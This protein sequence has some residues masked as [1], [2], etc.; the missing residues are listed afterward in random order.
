MDCIAQAL[1]RPRSFFF[2]DPE[3]R[4]KPIARHIG[5]VLQIFTAR[6]ADEATRILARPNLGPAAV[7]SF[8][9]VNPDDKSKEVDL[10]SGAVMR[11][12][13]D[14]AAK[15]PGSP[16]SGGF[17]LI[18]E[19]DEPQLI[20]GLMPRN[21]AEF[22]ITGD[23]IDDTDA[24]LAGRGGS[25]LGAAYIRGVGW[26]AASIADIVARRIYYTT[27]GTGASALQLEAL[28]PE[29]IPSSV[30]LVLDLPH[31]TILPVGPSGAKSLAGSRVSMYTGKPDRI[32][33]TATL[34]PDLL[35]SGKDL[36]G[37]ANIASVSSIGGSL[38]PALVGMGVIDAAIEFAK[39]FKKLDAIPGLLFALAARATVVDLEGNPLHFG[40]DPELERLLDACTPAQGSE[41]PAEDP[42]VLSKHVDELRQTS[43][44]AATPELANEILERLGSLRESG[45]AK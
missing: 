44:V 45:G 32:V 20:P 33:K 19:E 21:E 1:G 9:K 12:V 31:G 13:L 25:V 24:A 39:G 23:E 7:T 36:P 42:R 10:A 11:Q 4:F 15:S 5:E 34:A 6:C 43:V 35:S 16:L 14:A 8:A 37:A 22:A 17:Y 18:R 41:K 40:V 2:R 28:R 27:L 30:P 3:L 26:V 38:G 29:P